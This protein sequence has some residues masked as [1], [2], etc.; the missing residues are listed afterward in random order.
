MKKR[1]FNIGNKILLGFFSLI[2]IFTIIVSIVVVTNSENNKLIEKSSTVVRPSVNALHELTLLVTK[3]KMLA[4][5]WVHVQGNDVDKKALHELH[6]VEYPNL[7]K[8][9]INLKKSWE[10]DTTKAE[11]DSALAHFETLLTIEKDEIMNKLVTFDNYEDP[12]IKLSA[13]ETIESDVFPRSVDI[14]KDVKKVSDRLQKEDHELEKSILE[15]STGLTRTS[16]ISAVITIL[17]GLIGGFWMSRSITKPIGQIKEIIA[18]L[19]KGELPENNNIQY[20][21]DE[22]GEM[23]KAVENLV[24]GLKSTSSFAENI[25]NGNYDSAYNSLSKKDTLG[26]SLIEMR[27]NLKKVAEE[28]YKRNWITSGLAKFSE[29]L[30]NNNDNIEKLSED[31]IT[32]LIQYLGCNQGGLFIVNDDESEAFLE[33]K[34][35]YAWDKQ[36]YLEQ[37]IHIGEGLTGQAWLEKDTVYITEVPDEYIAITSGLGQSNPT[38]ILIVPMIV[39]DAVFGVIELASFKEFADFEIDFI[40]KLAESIASTVSTVKVNEQTQKLLEESTEMT[41]QMQSQ[42]EEMRQ[43]MEELQATQEEMKR[44]QVDMQGI[45]DSINSSLASAEYNINAEITNANEMFLEIYGFKLSEIKGRNHN[46]FLL[47]TDKNSKENGELWNTLKNGETI[48]GEYE[49]KKKDGSTIWVRSNYSPVKNTRGEVVKILELS[50]DIS[51]YKN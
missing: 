11:I 12:F 34:A 15:S 23:A 35:C 24:S 39:N 37:K 13:G 40:E 44:N 1:G 28:D 50:F 45:L 16:I 32:T 21:K 47:D 25:G 38:S 46:L 8:Q 51:S 48:T 43:N 3:S 6:N 31:I 36:K 14:M 17:I 27:N 2:V 18:K 5:N 33:L 29:T 20:N 9:I 30:R 42:E 26:N 22:I 19:G 10:N 7:K 49:R 4:T 41:E